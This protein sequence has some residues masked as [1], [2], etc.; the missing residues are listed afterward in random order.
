MPQACQSAD[1]LHDVHAEPLVRRS[2]RESKDNASSELVAGTNPSSTSR[3]V[4]SGLALQP[5][6]ERKKMMDILPDTSPS[7]GLTS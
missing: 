7:Y 5:R 2:K 6:A 4:V 1:N 3:V